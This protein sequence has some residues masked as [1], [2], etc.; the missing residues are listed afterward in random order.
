M[1]TTMGT[2]CQKTGN[3]SASLVPAKP[4]FRLI[5]KSMAGPKL[6]QATAKNSSKSIKPISQ[7]DI[8]L[9]RICLGWMRSESPRGF[10]GKAL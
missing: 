1:K 8:T 7:F 5:Q 9:V 3:S 6:D 2:P 4:A 10:R